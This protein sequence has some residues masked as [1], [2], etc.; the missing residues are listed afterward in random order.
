VNLSELFSQTFEFFKYVLDINL[1]LCRHIQVP[2]SCMSPTGLA[3][4]FIS[5]WVLLSIGARSVGLFCPVWNNSGIGRAL[6]GSH[7]G[8]ENNPG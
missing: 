6:Y 3:L 4:C 7:P 2:L 5:S 8:H 1:S